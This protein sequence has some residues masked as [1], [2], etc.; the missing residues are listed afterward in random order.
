[1]NFSF[2][3]RHYPELEEPFLDGL[4]KE[5]RIEPIVNEEKFNRD[6]LRLNRVGI[7]KRSFVYWSPAIVGASVASMA[8]LALLQML[9][10]SSNMKPIRILNGDAAQRIE[11][12]SVPLPEGPQTPLI[13]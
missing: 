8:L 13:R 11:R 6:I 7:V 9:T 2:R 3:K 12:P 5:S 1:M 10:S 4:L